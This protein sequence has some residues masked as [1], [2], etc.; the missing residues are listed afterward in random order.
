LE[1]KGPI[2]ITPREIKDF[3]CHAAFSSLQSSKPITRANV[4]IAVDEKEIGEKLICNQFSTQ[5]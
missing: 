4:Y 1:N 2:K 3:P 5:K